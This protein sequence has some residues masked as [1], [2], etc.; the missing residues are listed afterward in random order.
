MPL[1]VLFFVFF[2]VGGGK[3]YIVY[4]HIYGLDHIIPDSSYVHI[5]EN[6]GSNFPPPVGRKIKKIPS[7]K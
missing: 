3:I 1:F 7:K 5:Q 6:N 2:F 4:T